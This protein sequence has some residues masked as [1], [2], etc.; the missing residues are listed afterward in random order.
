MNIFRWEG[1][2]NA[3]VIKNP[4]FG[5]S[6]PGPLGVKLWRGQVTE[7]LSWLSAPPSD[8]WNELP[9]PLQNSGRLLQ[10]LGRCN[11]K[12]WKLCLFNRIL[13]QRWGGGDSKETNKTRT[14]RNWALVVSSALCFL[15]ALELV[16][17][18]G[19]GTTEGYGA[20]WIQNRSLPLS[21]LRN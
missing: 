13:I 11:W 5:E 2:S 17:A 4:G 15:R 14:N 6:T 19:T 7:T 20:R 21:P 1:T 18:A 9:L 10:V 3:P 16:D 8:H 12:F